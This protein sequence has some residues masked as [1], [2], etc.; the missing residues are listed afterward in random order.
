MKA[1]K[2]FY[3]DLR[4]VLTKH[5]TWESVFRLRISKGFRIVQTLGN[6]SI[7]SNDLLNVTCMDEYIHV[8]VSC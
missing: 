7:K 3:Y 4:S 6:Y 8:C 2:Q 1:D 5:Y